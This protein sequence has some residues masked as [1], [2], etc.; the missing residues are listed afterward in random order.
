[1]DPRQ[2]EL[3]GPLIA[4]W[5]KAVATYGRGWDED[6]PTILDSDGQ[7]TRRKK[8]GGAKKKPAKPARPAWMFPAIAGGAGDLL[9]GIVVAVMASSDREPEPTPTPTPVVVVVE[10][11]PVDMPMATPT[12]PPRRVE[13][14]PTP[15]PFTVFYN[16]G[17][18]SRSAAKA[19][20]AQL[21]SF[22]KP[23]VKLDYTVTGDGGHTVSL[24]NRFSVTVG[25]GG[26]S[27]SGASTHSIS[28]AT[29]SPQT[30]MRVQYDG[31]QVTIRVGKKRHGPWPAKVSKG[32]PAWQ[33]TLDQGVSMK[34]LQAS[35]QK[36]D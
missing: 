25:A 11:V 30:R 21:S 36:V 29:I 22:A 35:S 13:A 8:K 34:S 15:I 19:V 3:Y 9:V 27:F 23:D 31:E 10:D 20:G 28:S 7:P 2:E 12:P 1:M 4:K 33:F 14:T 16:K 6:A 26:G 5:K 32:F 24:K 18:V 17:E